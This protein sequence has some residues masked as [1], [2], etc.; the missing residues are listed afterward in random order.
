METSKIC[1]TCLEHFEFARADLVEGIKKLKQRA[2]ED[3]IRDN[4][5]DVDIQRLRDDLQRYEVATSSK[6][7]NGVPCPWSPSQPDQVVFPTQSMLSVWNLD[8]RSRSFAQLRESLN[9]TGCQ[10]CE[11]L[12]S[13]IRYVL[14]RE[15]P[16]SVRLA[17][18]WVFKKG[19][20]LPSRLQFR[21]YADETFS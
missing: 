9:F 2:I 15:V 7:G 19:G 3:A 6:N 14:G 13:M 11:S 1:S 21:V 5:S 4:F 12:I 17:S 20:P 10:L 16:D 8:G 18:V